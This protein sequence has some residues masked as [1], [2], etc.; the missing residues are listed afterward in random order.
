MKKSSIYSVVIML[1]F[2]LVIANKSQAQQSFNSAEEKIVY[3]KNNGLPKYDG[4]EIEYSFILKNPEETKDSDI[5]EIK[6]LFPNHKD[7][8]IAN[9]NENTYLYILTE[10]DRLNHERYN[11]ALLKYPHIIA[12]GKRNYILK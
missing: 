2:L 4:I 1:L 3:N 6:N 12:K 5:Q 10:G 11:E 8:R 7:V 9:V